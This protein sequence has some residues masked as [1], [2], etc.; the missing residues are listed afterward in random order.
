M[1]ASWQRFTCRASPVIFFLGT[2]ACTQKATVCNF[3]SFCLCLMLLYII[4]SVCFQNSLHHGLSELLQTPCVLCQCLMQECVNYTVVH[5][6]ITPIMKH[7]CVCDAT[8]INILWCILWGTMWC[9]MQSIL[10]CNGV[11]RLTYWMKICHDHATIKFLQIHTQQYSRPS[12]RY[13]RGTKKCRQMQFDKVLNTKSSI[14]AVS[15]NV[16]KR[17]AEERRYMEKTTNKKKA[18]R[19]GRAGRVSSTCGLWLILGSCWLH[20]TKCCRG[21]LLIAWNEMLLRWAVGNLP[22]Y[23]CCACNFTIKYLGSYHKL[24][25]SKEV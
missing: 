5:A 21:G 15:D 25:A 10:W 18:G 16:F 1:H 20:E 13:N 2:F 3:F 7:C 19:A 23:F 17:E 8:G 9:T 4:C 24:L 12:N 22:K 14:S 11:H 6:N